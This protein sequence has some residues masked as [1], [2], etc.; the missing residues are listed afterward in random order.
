MEPSKILECKTFIDKGSFSYQFIFIEIILSQP[1]IFQNLTKH[2]LTKLLEV[3][4]SVFGYKNNPAINY[5]LLSLSSTVLIL[6]RI[7]EKNQNKEFLEIKD[8]FFKCDRFIKGGITDDKE[9]LIRIK[10][11]AENYYKSLLP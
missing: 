7:L 2:D 5:S 3:A 4:I 11:M 9:M 6:G 1:N 10:S 8:V